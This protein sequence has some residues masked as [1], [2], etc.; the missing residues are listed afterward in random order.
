[1]NC[2][3]DLLKFI[4]H[5]LLEN[6]GDDLKYV[7]K[8]KSSHCAERLQSMAS[9]PFARVTYSVALDILNQVRKR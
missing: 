5:T 3:E 9:I 7:P 4:C 6:S 8:Q 2:T 1:M